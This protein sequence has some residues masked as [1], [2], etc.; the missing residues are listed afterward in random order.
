MSFLKKRCSRHLLKRVP[1]LVHGRGTTTGSDPTHAWTSSR[2]G[3]CNQIETGNEGRMRPEANGWILPKAGGKSG[4]RSNPTSRTNDVTSRWNA[5][6]K[7][8]ESGEG[9]EDQSLEDQMSPKI[10]ERR[11]HAASNAVRMPACQDRTTCGA[12][13]IP[14]VLN[15]AYPNALTA[16]SSMVC[17]NSNVSYLSPAR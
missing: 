6:S 17:M 15:T 2:P 1:S 4:F 9:T 14:V 10:P 13:L 5:S 3:N 8:K 12:M 11:G 7:P 16:V